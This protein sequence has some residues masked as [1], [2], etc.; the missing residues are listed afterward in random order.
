MDDNRHDAPQVK[1]KWKLHRIDAYFYQSESGRAEQSVL[2]SHLVRV[3][4][5]GRL[6]LEFKLL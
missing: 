6:A 3:G 2:E 5:P 1:L 4:E